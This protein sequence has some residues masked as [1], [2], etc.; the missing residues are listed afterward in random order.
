MDLQNAIN[1][2]IFDIERKELKKEQ[3]NEKTNRFPLRII[4]KIQNKKD[5]VSLET[6]NSCSPQELSLRLDEG[7]QSPLF[8]SEQS[9]RQR[10]R[11]TGVAEKNEM[12][13]RLVK[14]TLKNHIKAEYA[15]QY[16]LV[17]EKL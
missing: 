13:R 4:R 6:I 15:K 16:I 7:R 8:N 5:Y 3:R 11:R 1:S 17:D 9:D 14:Q 2:A 10:E 12:E